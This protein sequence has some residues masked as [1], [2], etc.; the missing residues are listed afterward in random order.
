[1]TKRI[2]SLI[3]VLTLMVGCMTMGY[4]VSADAETYGAEALAHLQNMGIFSAGLDADDVMTRGEFANAVYNMVGNNIEYD[5]KCVFYDVEASHPYSAAID[6]CAQNG[7]MTGNDGWFRPDDSVT[8]IEGMTVMARVLNYTEY[9]KSNG[10]YT[11]GYYT[12]ARN[13]GLLSGTGIVSSNDAMLVGNAAAMFYNAL[14]CNVNKLVAVNPLYHQYTDDTNSLAYEY[15]G[16]SYAKGVMTSNGDCDIT[17]KGNVGKYTVIVDK[18]M[19]SSRLLGSNDYKFYIGQEVGL[20][21]D[22]DGN[23]VSIVPTGKST[24]ASIVRSDYASKN[25]NVIK[26][27]D[28]EKDYS[29]KL[30]SDVVYIKNGKA[31]VDFKATGFEKSEFSDM[32][33]IDTDDDGKCDYVFV[34]VYDTFVVN[35]KTTEGVITSVNNTYRYDLSGNNGKAVYVYDSSKNLKTADHIYTEYVVSVME[36]DTFIYVVYSNSKVSGEVTCKE[37]YLI[38]IDGMEIDIPNGTKKYFKDISFGDS[39]TVYFDF[40]GRAIYV[41]DGYVSGDKEP[42]GFLIKSELKT[43]IDKKLVLKLL[44]SEGNIEVFEIASKFK[45]N[46][47]PYKRSELLDDSLFRVDGAVNNTVILYGLNSAGE[48]V[49]V[50]FPKTEL[51][52]NEDG[53]IKAYSREESQVISNGTLTSTAKKADGTYF[54]GLEFINANTTIFTVPNDLDNEEEF[55]VTTKTYIPLSTKLVWDTYHFSKYNSYVD[56]AVVYGNYAQTSFDSSLSVVTSVG[57]GYDEKENEVVSIKAY[58]NNGETVYNAPLG[59]EFAEYKYDSYGNKAAST[60]DVSK[61]KP[62]DVV[63]LG[64]DKNGNVRQGERIYE[65]NATVYPFKSSS[66]AGAYATHSLYLTDGYVAFNDKSIIR[67]A[68]NKDDAMTLDGSIFKKQGFIFTSA[69]IY[70]VSDSKRGVEVTTGAI[71]DVSVGDYVIYQGRAGVAK[72]LVVFKDR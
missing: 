31:V 55:S 62:G 38:E 16:L 65:Y 15:L 64:T 66:K 57:R 32:S 2:L 18:T 61:L 1:M 14:R 21:Y 54:S 36:S 25:G 30:D 43:G 24:V 4:T 56:V 53:F 5:A 68:G 37:E 35:A 7:Y 9:A 12:T 58:T 23:I 22:K 70:F 51:N 69:K 59:L 41:I 3:V 13:I 63:R 44:T 33:L 10:D 67:L 49:S 20:F 17:D 47:K 50:T 26:Y 6:Y 27:S 11:L 19:Y 40:E 48:I 60:V 34:N 39:V 45:I 71:G 46:G 29:I 72:Y 42:F 28:D 8:Y 52:Y